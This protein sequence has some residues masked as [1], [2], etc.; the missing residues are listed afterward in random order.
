MDKK[1]VI[2]LL[3]G[4]IARGIMWGSSAIGT[5]IGTEAIDENTAAGLAAYLAS[6]IVA[7][8]AMIWSKKK[9]KKLADAEPR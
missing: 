7:I 9:D 8:V 5:W 2:K 6:A 3:A 1:A 4:T